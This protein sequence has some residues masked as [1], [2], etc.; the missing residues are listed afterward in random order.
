MLFLT[1]S[2]RGT[3]MNVTGAVFLYPSTQFDPTLSHTP[4]WDDAD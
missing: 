3:M 1:M 2:P 4:S